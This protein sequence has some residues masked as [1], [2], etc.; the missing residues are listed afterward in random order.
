MYLFVLILSDDR[1][2]RNEY[3]G[4][5]D[6]NLAKSLSSIAVNELSA[7]AGWA[8]TQKPWEGLLSFL[9]I[10]RIEVGEHQRSGDDTGGAAHRDK[11]DCTENK[12]EKATDFQCHDSHE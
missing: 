5:E 12:C 4:V 3:L 7:S 10:T 8:T 9:D 2:I 11:P 1:G 6:S